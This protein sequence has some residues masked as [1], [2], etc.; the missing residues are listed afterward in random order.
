MPIKLA[1]IISLHSDAS[2]LFAEGLS[3]ASSCVHDGLARSLS[4]S[5]VESVAVVLGEV[6][7]DKGLTAVLVD[8]L[9]NLFRQSQQN[10]CLSRE[11]LAPPTL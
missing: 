9:E 8:S 2:N 3:P 7:T 5:I 6:V 4:K 10:A 1:H 11:C